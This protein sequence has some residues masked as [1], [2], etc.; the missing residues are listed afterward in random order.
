MCYVCSTS[1]Q[2]STVSPTSPDR[3]ITSEVIF[4]TFTNDTRFQSYVHVTRNVFS[5]SFLSLPVPLTHPCSNRW[6]VPLCRHKVSSAH[7]KRTLLLL[8]LDTA[9]GQTISPPALLFHQV[10]FCTHQD[11]TLGKNHQDVN[12]DVIPPDCQ[13]SF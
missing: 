11:R 8:V 2:P 4:T 13:C 1:K 3:F 12:S 5:A 9:P 6:F 7:H 10:H